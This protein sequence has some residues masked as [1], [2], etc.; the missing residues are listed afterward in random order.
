MKLLVVDCMLNLI[1]LLFRLKF[2][3]TVGILYA[4]YTFFTTGSLNFSVPP[5]IHDA[6]QS[7]GFSSKNTSSHQ[8]PEEKNSNGDL[9][10]G[11][12][13][14]A[15]ELVSDALQSKSSK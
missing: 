14:K 6:F 2:L 1:L 8:A 15:E 13:K 4:A 7:L 10:E 5:V 3:I 11:L 12:I 9:K